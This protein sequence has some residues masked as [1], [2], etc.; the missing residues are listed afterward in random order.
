MNVTGCSASTLGIDVFSRVLFTLV[1]VKLLLE[2]ADY[3]IMVGRLK[4]R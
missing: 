4:V 2:R 3:F 1:K